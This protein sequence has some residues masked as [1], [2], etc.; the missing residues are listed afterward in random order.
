MHLSYHRNQPLSMSLFVDYI[1][2]VVVSEIEK[3]AGRI[4]KRAPAPVTFFYLVEKYAVF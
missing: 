3:E 4:L 2:K 1:A